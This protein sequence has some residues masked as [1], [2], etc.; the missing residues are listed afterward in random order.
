MRISCETAAQCDRI[1]EAMHGVMEVAVFWMV[2]ILVIVAVASV[3]LS[4]YHGGDW[5]KERNP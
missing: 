2:C 3:A 4:L 1:A 5:P